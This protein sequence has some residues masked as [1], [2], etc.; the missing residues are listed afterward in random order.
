[1]KSH[2]HTVDRTA[3]VVKKAFV[4][5]EAKKIDAND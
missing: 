2:G 3:A 1:M 5:S 4:A